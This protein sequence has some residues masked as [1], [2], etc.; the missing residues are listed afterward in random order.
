MTKSRGNGTGSVTSYITS[1]GKKK[2]RV[3]VT[4]DTYFDAESEKVRTISKSSADHILRAAAL[5]CSRSVED[6]RRNL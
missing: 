3:R 1:K 6:T 2:Y 4:V 5:G